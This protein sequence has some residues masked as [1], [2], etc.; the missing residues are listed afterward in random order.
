M[1]L[2]GKK[3]THELTVGGMTCQ[4]CVAHVTKALAGVPGVKDVAVDLE[5]GAATV[6]A[7]AGMD[8]AGLAA[9]VQ[10]AGYDAAPAA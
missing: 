8:A 4:N 7:K 5:K 1:A 9:A 3:E 2:F 6:T 10:A